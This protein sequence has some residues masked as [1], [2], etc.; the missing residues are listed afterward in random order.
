MGVRCFLSTATRLQNFPGMNDAVR[1]GKSVRGRLASMPGMKY[2]KEWNTDPK[3]IPGTS[4]PSRT[5]YARPKIVMQRSQ[6]CDLLA[7]KVAKPNIRR[8]VNNG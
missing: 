3:A 5:E 7:I 6:V 4:L 1:D 8:E 2:G